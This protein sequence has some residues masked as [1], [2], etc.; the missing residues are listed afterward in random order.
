MHTSS[1]FILFY[2]ILKTSIDWFPIVF[3]SVTIWKKKNE[4]LNKIG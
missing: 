1:L 2:F 3:C 4:N